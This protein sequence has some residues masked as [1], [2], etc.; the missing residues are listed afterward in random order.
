M[1]N[2]EMLLKMN[3]QIYHSMKEYIKCSKEN[4]IITLRYQKHKCIISEMN[5][6][7]FLRF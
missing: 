2:M 7:Y 4:L 1:T 3:S 5:N 6:F